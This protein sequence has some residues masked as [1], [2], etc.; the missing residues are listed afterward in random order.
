MTVIIIGRAYVTSFV[1]SIIITVREIVVLDI[2][3]VI[4]VI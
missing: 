4:V 2:P 3:P 1:A